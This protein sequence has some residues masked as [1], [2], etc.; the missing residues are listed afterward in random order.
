MS[1]RPPRARAAIAVILMFGAG[2]TLRGI[3]ARAE[4]LSA[5]NS[6]APPG[7][8]WYYRVDHTTQQKMLVY[9]RDW[10]GLSVLRHPRIRRLTPQG[11][12]EQQRLLQRQ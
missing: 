1:T 4:C 9:P 8:R 12:T 2:V 3:S 7:K 5:P 6:T 10:S 11:Q